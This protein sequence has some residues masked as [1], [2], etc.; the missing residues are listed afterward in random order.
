MYY[1]SPV[2]S[3]VAMSLPPQKYAGALRCFKNALQ[4]SQDAVEDDQ[5]EELESYDSAIEIDEQLALEEPLEGSAINESGIDSLHIVP[6]FQNLPVDTEGMGEDPSE[7]ASSIPMKRKTDHETMFNSLK[8]AS[9]NVVGNSTLRLYVRLWM[10]FVLFCQAHSFIR[11]E[12][13]F[14]EVQP[15]FHSDLPSWIA[16]WIMDKCDDMDIHTGQIKPLHLRRGSYNMA[17]KMRAA[18]MHKFGWDYQLGTQSWQE[19]P[20]TG[21]YVGN[22]S[23]SMVLSQYM[24][25]LHRR[26]AHAGE[27][28][29]SA[30]AVDERTLKM[31]WVFNEGIEDTGRTPVSRK[32]LEQD[33]ARWGGRNT[34]PTGGIAPFYLWG[35]DRARPWMCPVWALSKWSEACRTMGIQRQGYVFRKKIGANSISADIEAGMTSESFLE[36]FRNNLLDVDIDPWPYGT[37]S[38][39]RGGCQYLAMVL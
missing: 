29:T 30:R 33:P 35:L 5:E 36:C 20:V 14:D 34:H 8:V 15:N 38:F 10:L 26:K 32:E 7:G 6:R 25:S 19:H 23:L 1:S 28:V 31:L 3:L 11:H 24:V 12:S 9:K 2:P 27:E 22:P 17:Q 21:K 39:R 4:V 18:M 13:E 37:H 16:L